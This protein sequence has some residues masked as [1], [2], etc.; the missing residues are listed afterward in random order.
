MGVPE[1]RILDGTPKDLEP[2]LESYRIGRKIEDEKMWMAN[3]YTMNAVSA[4]VGKILIGKKCKASYVEK[5]L[6][7]LDENEILTRE[8]QETERKKLLMNLQLMQINFESKQ[9]K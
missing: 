3:I 6:L 4:A 8:E 1:E 9:K 7:Q 5:P 2:Y